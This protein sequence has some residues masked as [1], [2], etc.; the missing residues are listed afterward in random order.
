MFWSIREETNFKT[1]KD[2]FDDLLFQV[3]QFAD[4]VSGIRL[5]IRMVCVLIVQTTHLI[6]FR[7]KIRLRTATEGNHSTVFALFDT[8][9]AV[10][11]LSLTLKVISL[12]FGQ[13]SY[14]CYFVHV[15][16]VNVY[17]YDTLFN[18]INEWWIWRHNSWWKNYDN[19]GDQSALINRGALICPD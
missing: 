11:V 3:C 10:M 18:I 2:I 16:W 5:L 4:S 19:L 12:D 13:W 14:C 7:R 17:F 6:H 1:W 15:C 9:C 8:S